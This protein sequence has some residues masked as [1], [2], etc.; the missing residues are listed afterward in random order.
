MLVSFGPAGLHWW[1]Y[2][3][4]I[5]DALEAAVA[6]DLDLLPALMLRARRLASPAG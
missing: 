3:N 4:K 1:E 6:A 5:E 2:L